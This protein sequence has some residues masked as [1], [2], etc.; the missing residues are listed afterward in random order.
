MAQKANVQ[1]QSPSRQHVHLEDRCSHQCKSQRHTK[2]E[3]RHE[4]MFKRSL[5]AQTAT[6]G[7]MVHGFIWVGLAWKRVLLIGCGCCV[8]S[9]SL[10]LQGPALCIE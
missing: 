3:P 5:G 4:M 2:A 9:S 10:P 1:T 7:A 8:C 6:Q